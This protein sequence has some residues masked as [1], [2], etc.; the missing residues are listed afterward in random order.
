[1]E[2]K[3]DNN[4]SHSG[5]VEMELAVEYLSGDPAGS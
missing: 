5:L 1:M 2:R 3:G 4:E